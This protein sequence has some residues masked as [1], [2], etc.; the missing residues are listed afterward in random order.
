MG[1]YHGADVCDLVGLFI[2]NEITPIICPLNIGLY[3]E[4]GL[5]AIIQ[6]SGTIMERTKKRIIEKTSQI[7]FDI[8]IDI[9]NTTSNF[10]GIALNLP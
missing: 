10:L 4:E 3:S 1:S 9:Q 2:L 8:V 7:R 6:S 5:G